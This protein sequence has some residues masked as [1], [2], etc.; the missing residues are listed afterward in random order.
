MKN[1]QRGETTITFEYGIT[2]SLWTGSNNQRL[3]REKSVVNKRLGEFL[4]NEVIV[5]ILEQGCLRFAGDILRKSGVLRIEIEEF[6]RN[7][8]EFTL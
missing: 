7:I 4:E 6:D 3:M 2:L 8:N 1:H 5:E